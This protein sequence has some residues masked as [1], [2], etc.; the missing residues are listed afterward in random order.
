MDFAIKFDG[1]G[2]HDPKHWNGI[3][4]QTLN[5]IFIDLDLFQFSRKSQS[6]LVGGIRTTNHCGWI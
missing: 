3:N 1:G 2:Y 4:R 6:I 5:L